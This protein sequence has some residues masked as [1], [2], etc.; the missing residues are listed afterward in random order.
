MSADENKATTSSSTTTTTTTPT[1]PSPASPRESVDTSDDGTA[2][3]SDSKGAGSSSAKKDKLGSS[4]YYFKSTPKEEA[5]KYAPKPIDPAT[6]AKAAQ[7]DLA[8]Q[9]SAWNTAGTWEDRDMS[10]WAHERIKSLFKDFELTLGLPDCKATINSVSKVDGEASIV[11]TRGKRKVGYE[12]S[13]TAEYTGEHKS[14]AVSGTIE[15]PSVDYGDNEFEVV[16]KAAKSDAAHDAVRAAIAR[17]KIL[18]YSRFEQLV[19][20][21][22]AA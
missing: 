14:T 4:Y 21:L 18:I 10:S 13:F 17:N 3:P 1:S 16:V 12:L 2:S 9:G 20:E 6:Q 8:R 11:F 22:N 5:A 15:C 7:P 19:K